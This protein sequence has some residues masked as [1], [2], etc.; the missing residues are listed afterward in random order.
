MHQIQSLIA[1]EDVAP[2]LVRE[3]LQELVNIDE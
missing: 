3:T 2:E 1:T